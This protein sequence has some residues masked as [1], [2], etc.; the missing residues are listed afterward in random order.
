MFNVCY[1]CGEYSVD[2]TVDP[3]G[4]V[5]VCPHCGHRHPFRYLPLF[6][7]GGASGT[8]KSVICQQLIAW[9]L[10]VVL[11][12]SD[13]LWRPE[14]NKPEE[15]YRAYFETWLRMCKNIGQSGRPVVLFGAGS[16]VPTNI[17]PCL[18]SRYF[19][20]IH[21]LALVC[22]DDVLAGRLRARPQW[23]QSRGDAFVACQQSFNRWVREDGPR[24]APPISFIDTT[25]Q[26]PEV[27]SHAVM[28]WI[29]NRVPAR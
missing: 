14:F 5:A 18:E 21:Y 17:E 13:I 26:T 2:K 10:P 23:R 1:S 3:Q 9:D 25:R 7:V 29:V 6:M 20:A 27:T 15:S 16:G 11:L 28:E 24:L 4:P 19:S 22:D 8:G 12:D